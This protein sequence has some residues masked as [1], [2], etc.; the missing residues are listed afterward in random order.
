MSIHRILLPTVSLAA[1]WCS[2]GSPQGGAPQ[3]PPWQSHYLAGEAALQQGNYPRAQQHFEAARGAL[4][5]AADPRLVPI[6]QRLAGLEAL[7]GRLAP[8]ETLYVQALA[9]AGRALPSLDP[10]RVLLET[11]AA[12]FYLDQKKYPQAQELCT[13]ALARQEAQAEPRTPQLAAILDR[14]ADLHRAQGR[15]GLADSLGKRAMA[16]KLGAQAYEYYLQ[17]NYPQA[18]SLYRRAVAI[19]EKYLGDHPDLARTCRELGMLQQARGDY[20]QA[21]GLYRRAVA[22]QEKN[23]GG[24]PDLARTLDNLALLLRKSKREAEAETIEA[25]ARQLRQPPAPSTP[26]L[27]EQP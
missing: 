18:E 16:C 27:P 26:D 24:H 19:Q 4:A 8:A 9:L 20:P 2:C 12:A 14:L 22:I 21:E 10:Q 3:S 15:H 7:Q 23:P 25:R 5:D 6:L 17:G 11:Q 13:Q 1:L